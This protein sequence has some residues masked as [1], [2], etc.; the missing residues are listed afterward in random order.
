MV[1]NLSFW[2]LILSEGSAD[3]ALKPSEVSE[4]CFMFRAG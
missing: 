2:G 3:A 4:L 1:L